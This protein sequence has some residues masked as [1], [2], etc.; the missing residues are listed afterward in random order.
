VRLFDRHGATVM[1]TLYG[2]ALLQRAD[3]AL[4]ETDE[5]VREIQLLKGLAT[6]DLQIAMG[7]CAAEMSAARAVGE[8]V[9]QHAGLNCRLKLTS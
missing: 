7:V 8:L 1:P 9:A 5:L 2:T 3:R 6:G 4:G